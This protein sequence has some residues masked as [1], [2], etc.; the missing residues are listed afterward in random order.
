E[1]SSTAGVVAVLS[2]PTRPA[3]TRAPGA[4]GGE[5]GPRHAR[6]QRAASGGVAAWGGFAETSGGMVPSPRPA[7]AGDS[8][9]P[10]PTNPMMNQR[11][12]SAAMKLARL[13]QMNV[14]QVEAQHRGGLQPAAR[15][16]G[17]EDDVDAGVEPLPTPSPRK[18]ARI[19][20]ATG[21]V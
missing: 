8:P 12:L 14:L 9:Q 4:S 2:P 13:S 3:A 17:G 20:L 6:V 18:G 5:R 7:P 1:N 19:P 11:R 16:A 15:R 21:V 10:R